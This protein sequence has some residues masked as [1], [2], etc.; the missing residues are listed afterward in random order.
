MRY[1]WAFHLESEKITKKGRCISLREAREH[2]LQ[3]GRETDKR[4]QADYAAEGRD[5]ATESSMENLIEVLSSTL[6]SLLYIWLL[7]ILGALSL[8]LISLSA[9]GLMRI[10]VFFFHL[11]PE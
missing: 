10:G 7:L 5:L 9:S 2:A 4:R 11:L 1:S 8:R 3:V 6:G